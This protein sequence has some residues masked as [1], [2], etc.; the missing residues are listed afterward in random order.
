[1]D[2]LGYGQKLQPVLAAVVRVH[3]LGKVF[4]VDSQRMTGPRHRE[5]AGGHRM[6]PPGEEAEDRTSIYTQSARSV[7]SLHG[8]C[9]RVHWQDQRH[10]QSL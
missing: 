6:D 8:K 9:D 7:T 2:D 1:M 3:A 4:A 10:T 5:A